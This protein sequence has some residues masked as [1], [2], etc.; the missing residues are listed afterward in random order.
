[1]TRIIND[2]QHI[3]RNMLHG[4]YF[5]QQARIDYNAKHNI[6]YRKD[7]AEM[8]DSVVLISGGG[9]GHEPADFGYVGG[10]MLSIAVVGAIFTSPAAEQVLEAIRLVDRS[11][12]VLL[13]VKNF[14]ADVDIFL[15]AEALAREEGRIVDHIIV[16]D[17][18]SIEDD[19][20]YTKRRRGVAGTVLVHKIL[21]AAAREGYSLEQLKALGE[22]VVS[23][24][25]TLGVALSPV[26]DPTRGGVAWTLDDNEAYYGVGIHGEKGYR[27]EAFSSSEKLAIE[28]F[29]KLK[30]MYRWRQR[31]RFAMLVNGLGATPLVE[32]YIFANDIRRLCEL[33]NL[34]IRFVKVGSHLTSLDMEGISLSL[35]R[36]EDDRWE[37]W[38]KADAQVAKW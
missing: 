33:E 36:L 23:R 35:L 14:A 5:E 16:S 19:A 32:Q 28:L 37:G 25:H 34:D 27:K 17:D 12:S 3:V 7:L 10:G 24:L 4:F 29:N 2:A 9:S 30:R 22:A 18:V 8:G 31:D 38:L 20:S 6:I 21:G 26:D 1:M 15:Q 11:K 13:I